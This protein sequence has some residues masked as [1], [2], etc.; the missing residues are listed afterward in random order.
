MLFKIQRTGCCDVNVTFITFPKE[1]L[2][3]LIKFK[4]GTFPVFPAFEKQ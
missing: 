4:S 3:E 1:D 2:L